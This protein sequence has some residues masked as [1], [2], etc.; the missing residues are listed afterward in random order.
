MGTPDEHE[1]A[2][3]AAA[4]D[5]AE[6]EVHG[7]ALEQVRPS[8]HRYLMRQLRRAEDAEDLT[9]EVYLRLLR[10][11]TTEV[12]RFPR[13]YVLRVAVHVLYEFRH[14]RRKGRVEFDSALADD[15][16]RHLADDA[17]LPEATY[18]RHHNE[19]VVERLAQRLPAMQQAVLIMA[20]R[21][22]MSYEQ[23]AA[24]LDISASTARVHIYRALTFIRQEIAKEKM[25]P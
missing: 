12:I 11:A 22:K 21:E 10:L 24:K 19:G 15:A 8:L 23:I 9:Q 1:P 18:E 4:Q 13:A 7:I 6:A 25:T 5:R 2:T 20:T 3:S 17:D 16:S 14:R